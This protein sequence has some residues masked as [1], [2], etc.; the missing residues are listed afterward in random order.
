MGSV[1]SGSQVHFLEAKM[2]LSGLLFK[3]PTRYATEE[4]GPRALSSEIAWES[5]M[6]KQR[7]QT[8][9]PRPPD[10][11]SVLQLTSRAWAGQVQRDQGLETAG[12]EGGVGQVPTVC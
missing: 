11:A 12:C 8:R 7:I 3:K 2:L 10:S 9:V 5:K 1:T 4:S 6:G